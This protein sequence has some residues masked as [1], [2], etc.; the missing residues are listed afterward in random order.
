MQG[1]EIMDT[2]LRRL[3]R[4]RLIMAL[5]LSGLLM[6]CGGG[7]GTAGEGGS[8]QAEAGIRSETAD[9]GRTPKTSLAI[10]RMDQHQ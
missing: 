5:V 3:N 2:T 8:G 6:S 1:H 7:E 10:V 9:P 4:Q